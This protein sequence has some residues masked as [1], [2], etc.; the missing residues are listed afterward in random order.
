MPRFTH[1]SVGPDASESFGALPSPAAQ[2]LAAA[3]LSFVVVGLILLLWDFGWLAALL[4]DWL[5]SNLV[6]AGTV[7][8]ID[9]LRRRQAGV[10]GI[11]DSRPSY[12]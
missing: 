11:R 8:V 3:M 10:L 9:A 12:G 4:Y 7:L 6:F 1:K 5:A 2:G